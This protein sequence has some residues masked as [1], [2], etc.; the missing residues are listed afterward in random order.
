M[1]GKTVKSV[2]AAVIHVTQKHL[3]AMLDKMQIDAVRL[4]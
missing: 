3:C 2:H 1:F 4:S